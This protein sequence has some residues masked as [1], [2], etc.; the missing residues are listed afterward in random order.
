MRRDES[1]QILADPLHHRRVSLDARQ[2]HAAFQRR[3]DEARQPRGIDVVLQ[4]CA[5]FPEQRLQLACP[6]VEHL[7]QPQPK[8]LV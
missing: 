8:P 6:L 2:Q 5:H 7:V 1:L 3:H 4:L